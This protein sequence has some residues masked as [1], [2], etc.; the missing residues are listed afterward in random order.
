MEA[1]LANVPRPPERPEQVGSWA[2][3]EWEQKGSLSGSR[4]PAEP[5][6]AIG[7]EETTAWRHLARWG[8]GS[9]S[10]ADF[11]AGN[12]SGREQKHSCQL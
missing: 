10:P 2:P 3:A 6:Q 7:R 1:P 8:E 9:R 12:R 4:L 5:T 11:L